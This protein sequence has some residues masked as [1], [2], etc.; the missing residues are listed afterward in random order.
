M[1]QAEDEQSKQVHKE[2]KR[3]DPSK[4]DDHFDCSTGISPPK[5]IDPPNAAKLRRADGCSCGSSSKIE[6]P[7]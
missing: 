7:E 6:D 1:Q 2:S 5:Y 4:G 3:A